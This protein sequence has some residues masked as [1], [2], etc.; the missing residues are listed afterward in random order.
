MDIP[1]LPKNVHEGIYR[2][3][4]KYRDEFIADSRSWVKG[5]V[6]DYC[7]ERLVSPSFPESKS[8][9]YLLLGATSERKEE[10]RDLLDQYAGSEGFFI[11]EVAKELSTKLG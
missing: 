6:L 4:K 1:D 10:V 9:I 3:V 2:F 11:A 5:D 8:W 7:K